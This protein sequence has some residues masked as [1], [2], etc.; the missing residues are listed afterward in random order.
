MRMHALSD[1]HVCAALQDLALR[2]TLGDSSEGATTAAT[3]AVAAAKRHAAGSDSTPSSSIGLAEAERDLARAVYSRRL[4]MAFVA[5]DLADSLLAINDIRS[6]S[7][8]RPGLAGHPATLALA[9]LLSAAVS[10]FKYWN[11]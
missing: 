7:G 11:A 5:Q 8:K 3:T 4:R 2:G 6:A 9:G 1:D 10:S